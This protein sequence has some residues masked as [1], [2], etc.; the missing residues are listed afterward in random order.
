M[1][2]RALCPHDLIQ[3]IIDE[4]NTYRAGRRLVTMGGSA[5]RPLLEA[6]VGDRGPLRGVLPE[7][8][9]ILERIARRDVNLLIAALENHPALNIVVWAVGHGAVKRGVL[10]R[11]AHRALSS[12]R[13]HKDPGIRAVANYHLQ[14]IEKATRRKRKSK[15]TRS[16]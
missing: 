16:R 1:V 15:V 8:V 3:N 10:N 14:R 2:K 7:L 11:R 6:I 4:E 9:N 12:H 5:V 13:K